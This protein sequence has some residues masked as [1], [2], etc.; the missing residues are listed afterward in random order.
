MPVVDGKL[1]LSRDAVSFEAL[2]ESVPDHNTAH[3]SGGADEIKLDTLGAP[4]DITTLNASTA[5]HGLCPKGTGTGTKYLKDDLTWDTPAGTGGVTFGTTAGTACE[6]ND[7]RLS[8]ARTPSLHAVSHKGTGSDS[9][10]LDEL[11]APDDIT[12]LNVSTTAHGLCPKLSGST[13]QFFRGDGVFAAVTG[14]SGGGAGLGTTIGMEGSGADY[15]CDGTA[16]N[17]QFQQVLNAVAPGGIIIVL[18]GTYR[19]TSQVTGYISCTMV[20]AGKVVINLATGSSNTPVLVFSGDVI[21]SQA[22][23]AK[24]TRGLRAV[25]LASASG[26]QAGD[27]ILVHNDEYWCPTD[28]NYGIGGTDLE[29][30][31]GELYEVYSVSG[32]IVTLTQSLLRDYETADNSRAEIYRPIEVHLEGIEFIGNGDTAD[33]AGVQF[34]Y[35]KNSSFEKCKLTKHGR[36]TLIIFTCY[37]VVVDDCYIAASIKAGTGYGISLVDGTA[38]VKIVNS[39][40]ENCRHCI[41]GNSTGVALNRGIVISN[42]TF[43]GATITDANVID[44]HPMC[45]DYTIDGNTFYPYAGYYAFYDGAF[46]SVF[47]NNYVEGGGGVKRRGTMTGTSCVVEGNTVCNTGGCALYNAPSTRHASCLTIK[48]NNVYN[49]AAGIMLYDAIFERISITGNTFDTLSDTAINI[50]LAA[51]S[52]VPLSASITGNTIKNGQ[53]NGIYLKRTAV[54]DIFDANVTGNTLINMGQETA[55]TYNGI[56]LVDITGASVNGNIIK[57]YTGSLSKGIAESELVNGCDYN[58]IVNNIIKGASTAI[59]TVG[60]NDVIT[61]NM[62]IP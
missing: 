11:D 21:T 54:D 58:N 17:V 38:F 49:S 52:T 59:S 32:N 5:K 37:N 26:V 55:A 36:R 4:T 13:A 44:A 14:A 1:V 27:L 41:A 3:Q 39:R 45:I 24:G 57:N 23:T 19:F 25:T 31:K 16:D 28:T 6:G 53:K 20:A 8:D 22:L 15:I 42:S 40:I 34:T 60:A 43:V 18:P 12:D 46:N 9:I 51:S 56:F 48:G 35:C 10:K 47:S 33:V 2:I 62:T 61:P 50:T 30:R 7:S 29:Q